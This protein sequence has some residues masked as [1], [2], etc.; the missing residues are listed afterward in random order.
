MF[1]NL[2]PQT[3][4][5]NISIL[6]PCSFL[7]DVFCQVAQGHCGPIVGRKH[8]RIP[9]GAGSQQLPRALRLAGEGRWSNSHPTREQTP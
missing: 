5:R 3:L 9:V 4:V 1:S 8:T 7:K 2:N 6:E